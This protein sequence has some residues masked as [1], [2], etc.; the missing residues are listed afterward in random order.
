[1]IVAGGQIIVEPIMSGVGVAV[2]PDEDLPEVESL[3]RKYG[4]LLHVDG[5]INGFGRTGK[6]FGH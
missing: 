2:P 6:M 1:M 3:C 4:I 5:V